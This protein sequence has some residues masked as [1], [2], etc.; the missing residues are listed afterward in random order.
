M[1]STV[2]TLLSR[3]A[4]AA[5]IAG[6]ATFGTACDDDAGGGAGAADL[7]VGD[8][9]AEG[10]DADPTPSDGGGGTD[11][12]LPDQGALDL[13][14]ADQGTAD[15]GAADLGTIALQPEAAPG[16]EAVGLFRT[17]VV[18][19]AD[20][21]PRA[22]PVLWF[23]PTSAVPTAHPLADLLPAE[24]QAQFTALSAA[25]PPGCVTPSLDLALDGPPTAAPARPWIV[26][27]HCHGCL[28]LSLST[29]ARHLASHGYVV[30][31]VEHPGG[32]VFDENP[33]LN[34]A[35][36]AVRLADVEAVIDG[37]LA[38]AVAPQVGPLDADRLGLMGHSFG[39]VTAGRITQDDARAKAVLA[40]AAPIDNP[41]LP[42]TDAA[43]FTKPALFWRAEEDGSI[44]AAGN[45]LIENNYNAVQGPAWLWKVAEAGHF[46]LTDIAGL[47]PALMAGCGEGRRQVGRAPFTWLA[48]EETRATA[49]QA[50]VGF[51]NAI[52]RADAEA[53]V[54]LSAPGRRDI[55]VESRGSGSR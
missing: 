23:Y 24:R 28:A 13:G 50:A 48:P 47:T 17:E 44:T 27:S 25:A 43:A 29:V 9:M 33:P 10:A 32:T 30:A 52:L 26:A 38:G 20:D 34:S 41:L 14:A 18:R 16:P 1:K 5:L 55:T 35:F 54:R 22:V 6:G 42:G 36:L 4:L 31:V 12:G 37:A 3:W 39:S 40:L 11:Q 2:E 53:E 51:F 8:A 15:G 19:E 46:G 49:A 7:T 45:A 21:G